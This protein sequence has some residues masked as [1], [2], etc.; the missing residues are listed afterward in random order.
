MTIDRWE[1]QGRFP[2][3]VQLGTNSVGWYADEVNRWLE[4]RPA[5]GAAA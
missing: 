3:R 1:K 2:K 5:A 4:Q